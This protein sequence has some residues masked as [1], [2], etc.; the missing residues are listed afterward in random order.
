VRNQN[1]LLPGHRIYQRRS[2]IWVV[3]EIERDALS[4][5]IALTAQRNGELRRITRDALRRWGRVDA[6]PTADE[7][8][9]ELLRRDGVARADREVQLAA[10]IDRLRRQV[11]RLRRRVAY[12]EA[13]PTL[14]VV[15]TPAKLVRSLREV[16][17]ERTQWRN[18]AKAAEAKAAELHSLLLDLSVVVR[19]ALREGKRLATGEA[20]CASCGEQIHA[21]EEICR[22]RPVPLHWACSRALYSRAGHA[23]K[24]AN[25]HGCSTIEK[26]V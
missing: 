7:T 24:T 14:E 23:A 10:E 1:Y 22:P 18:R 11:D 8:F 2:A 5:L 16:R 15:K 4:H 3:V 25:L 21:G 6:T 19:V 26:P 9:A 17:A 13:L 20:T 12:H